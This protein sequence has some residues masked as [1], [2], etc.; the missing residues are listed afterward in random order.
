MAL[1]VVVIAAAIILPIVLGRDVLDRS[2][3]EEDIAAQ[4]EE[5]F[6]VSVDVTCDDEMVVQNGATYECTG[7]TEDGE[8]VTLQVAITDA[9]SAAYTWDV[10]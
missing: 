9:D 5:T 8:D 4:F 6:G 2:R 10:D 3:A 1:A 7:Q